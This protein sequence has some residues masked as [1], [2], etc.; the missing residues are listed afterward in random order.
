MQALRGREGVI[1]DAAEDNSIDDSPSL[2]IRVRCPSCRVNTSGFACPNC[3]FE[4]RV[5]GGIVRALSPDRVAHYSQFIEDYERIR[6]AEGRGSEDDDFYRGLP[7]RDASGRHND[8]WQIRARTY[9]CLTERLLKPSSFS[10]RRILDLGA[11]NCWLSYRLAL[12]G[13][14]PCAVDLLTNE[15]DGL[16]A[17]RHYRCDLPSLFPR[18][19]A[20]HANLPFQ[21][22][23]FDAV[24]FNA[25]FHYVEDAEGALREAF[26]CVRRSGMVIISD[27]P[28][29]SS[30]KSGRQM[31]TERRDNFWRRF[32]TPSASLDSMEYLTDDRLH[33]LE[34]R[35]S[36]CFEAYS[37]RYGLRWAMRPFLAKLR[38]RREPARFRIYVAQKVSA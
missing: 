13:F 16:G 4:L 26:R 6:A 17:A 7:Y 8:Q 23:Q 34:Q 9:R 21:D 22:D 15:D 32:G 31:V 19:Q 12:A 33:L 1:A 18:F 11:G 25:S 37:P 29:Y 38:G 14:R 5:N 10:G 27:T 36:I 30:E 3:G 28:W 35:L 2:D 24:I 20:E